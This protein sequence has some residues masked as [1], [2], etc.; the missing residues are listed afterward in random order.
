VIVEP[1]HLAISE[2]WLAARKSH[3]RIL[4]REVTEMSTEATLNDPSLLYSFVERRV[5]LV[6]LASRQVHLG[7]HREL[8]A[9]ARL[10]DPAIVVAD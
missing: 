10:I 7:K 9:Q 2:F 5:R 1:T 6:L 8:G 3:K 4:A